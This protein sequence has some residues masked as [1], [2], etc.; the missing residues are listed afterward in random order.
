M[1]DLDPSTWMPWLERLRD[2]LVHDVLAPATL[3]QLVLVLLLAGAGRLLHPPL[4]RLVA[5]AFTRSRLEARLIRL[6]RALQALAGPLVTMVLLWLATGFAQR[7]GL[8]GGLLRIAATLL[9]AWVVIRLI[10]GLAGDSAV[11][12]LIG[13][14]AW[15]VAA[16][17]ILGLLDLTLSLLDSA[18]LSFGTLRISVLTVVKGVLALGVLLWASVAVSGLLERR[19]R[20]LPDFT[21]SVQALLVTLTRVVLIATAVIA[22]ISSVGI[23]LSVLAVF[24]GALGVGLGFGLQKVVGNLVSGVILLLDK[25]VKPGDVIELGDTYGWVN[26]LGARYTSIITRDATEH[27]IPNEDLITQRVVNWSFTSKQVRQHASI[28]IAYTADLH[29][30]MALCEQAALDTPRVLNVPAPRCLLTGFGDSSVDLQLRYWINDPEEGISNLRSD[31]LLR[32]WDLFH[33]HG[34]EIP[35]PQR[36]LHLRS[37]AVVRVRLD[38]ETPESG[39]P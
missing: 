21:P 5:Q 29:K 38:G 24:T 19:I 4:R 35:Y 39:T 13:L 20:A 37:P 18:A 26:T 28:G 9:T 7:L 12:R 16:L 22:A 3:V 23:D 31:V 32:V 34:I 17:N 14:L 36:D 27:L 1:T 25:S 6:D 10:S 11:T 2:W 15:T 33:E 30:A 8:E